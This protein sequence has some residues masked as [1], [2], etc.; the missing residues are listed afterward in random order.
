MITKV[1]KD[2]KGL[3]RALF[4]KAGEEYLADPSAITSLD[5]YFACLKS[6]ADIN[7]IYTVLPLD[8]PVFSIDTNTRKITV[9]TDFSKNGISVQGDEVSE[10]L[11]FSVDRYTDAM[12]LFRE[13]I[14]IAIQWESA[15]DAK[16]HTVQGISKEWIRDISSLKQ[17]GKMLF[18]WAINSELTNNP[19]AI[20]FSVRFY[21]FDEEQKLD[22]S[23]NTL[24]AS[25]VINP[26]IDYKFDENGES[27]VDIIDSSN[28]IKNRLKDSVTP[29]S[30][31]EAADPYF[32]INLPTGFTTTEDE[33]EYNSI[34]LIP[35]EWDSE[36]AT[37]LADAYPFMVQATSDDG[38]IISYQWYRKPLGS[39]IEDALDTTDGA[40]IDYVLT[41]DTK[42]S[43]DYPYYKWVVN[44]E[45]GLGAYKPIQIAND[46]IDTEIPEEEKSLLYERV[47]VY[48]AYATGDYR[49]VTVNRS[50]IAKKE[51][52]SIHVR[53]PGPDTES[54]VTVY[55][56]GQKNSYLAGDDAGSVELKATGSTEQ[57]GD[58]IAY[59]WSDQETGATLREEPKVT[60][61]G[62]ED[63]VT[64]GLIAA[65]DRPTYDKTFILNT[66]ASRNG[67]NTP[68][69][70]E[71]FRVTDEAHAVTVSPKE[72]LIKLSEGEVKEIG[73][74]V[75]VNVVSDDITYQWYK[76]TKDTADDDFPIPN[77]TTPTIKITSSPELK[78]E[79]VFDTGSG[80][81]YCEVTNHANNS[82]AAID[83]EE[84]SVI[85]Y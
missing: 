10:I 4:E 58:K 5:E 31:A 23:L 79:D 60:E 27:S 50:G 78:A 9:P 40:K 73:I 28:L 66:Y 62:V 57:E 19:G 54:F 7:P 12:D 85:P 67:D 59:I 35:G 72:S 30:V 44:S 21:H 32:I 52:E 47:S 46:L 29:D 16:G 20:K 61:N 64:I 82:V 76:L 13:D 83:S 84:I 49:V 45:T 63:V 3:Y 41:E 65:A 56:E 51:L 6:L 36:S 25:A 18:G 43:A 8:E 55:P 1:T 17:E 74:N 11:Y 81:Y 22:F 34:D 68:L 71:T 14:N 80:S 69:S 26:S 37:Q 15:P 39:E 38:G 53:I 33:V 75:V 77:A 24:T 2:N 42:Y 48:T 70:T